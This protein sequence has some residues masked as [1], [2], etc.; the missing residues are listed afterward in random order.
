MIKKARIQ[1]NYLQVPLRISDMLV[2]I[3]QGTDLSDLFNQ[4]DCNKAEVVNEVIKDI[5][6]RI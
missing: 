5:H 1:K 2:Q 4:K 3:Y 6:N